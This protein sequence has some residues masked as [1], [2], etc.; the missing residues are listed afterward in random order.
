MTEKWQ[1][2]LRKASRPDKIKI[3][4]SFF[5]TGKG[6]YGEGDIF[7]GI[8]VPDNRAIA[9]KY[10]AQP[11]DVIERML[12]DEI[13]EFRLSGFL[14]LVE[15]FKKTKSTEA[16]R[17]I[18]NF[19]VSHGTNANNWDLVDL[20]APYIL[21]AFHLEH[22]DNTLLDNLS[23]SDNLWL[24][25]IAIVSTLMQIR[26]N[27]FDDTLRL[28][29]RYLTHPHPLIHK[30]TG[31]MLRETGKRD[32]SILLGFLDEFAQ[33]MPRTALRYAIEKLPDEMRRHYMSMP[34]TGVQNQNITPK[35]FSTKK[36]K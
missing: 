11:F 13:H 16:R 22:P 3:L 5:K 35:H 28:A 33:T 34:Q 4:S 24:Q 9:K 29:K 7:I 15:R 23:Y 20:S 18:V 19:Y 31:W 6:E 21:G 14:A 32:E 27:R 30:A 1:N 10:S 17:E 8:T 2:E 26:G 25:R 36:T 12:T